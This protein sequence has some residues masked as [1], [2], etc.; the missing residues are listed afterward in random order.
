[1]NAT[2]TPDVQGCIAEAMSE[3][4]RF[5]GILHTRFG[6]QLPYDILTNLPNGLVQ[7][8]Q[9]A[10]RALRVALVSTVGEYF[11]WDTDEVTIFAAETLE[12]SNVHNLAAFLYGHVESRH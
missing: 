3:L 7:R 9:L 2:S 4:S 12:D 11:G 6:S 8:D 10:E 5:L 1:M